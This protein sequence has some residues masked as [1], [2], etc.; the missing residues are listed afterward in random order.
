MDLNAWISYKVNVRKSSKH[1]KISID[2][3]QISM[4]DNAATAVF[5]QYYSSSLLKDSCT[6]KLAL[7]KI[8]DKW[9]I[10]RETVGSTVATATAVEKSAPVAGEQKETKS[11]SE[12]AVRGL[13]NK[14]LGSW[15]SGDMKTYRGCYAA[16]FQSKGMDLNA[17]ISYKVNVRKSSKHIKISID[18]LQISMDDNA[19]TAVF[20][21]YYS[22]SLL[23]DTCTKTLELRKIKDKWEIYRETVGS[24]AATV[25]A[26]EKSTP[27][28]GEQ[29][30][31]V[32][33]T[34]AEKPVALKEDVAA[35]SATPVT[36]KDLALV[37]SKQ[38]VIPVYGDLT[39]TVKETENAK[40]KEF[41]SPI[42]EQGKFYLENIPAGSWPAVIDYQDGQCKFIFVVPS[43]QERIVKME[44]V[45]CVLQ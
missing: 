23:K 44:T 11:V 9:E 33:A 26:V 30:V 8:D 28:A 40:S 14:W 16:D 24:T 43:S 36:N 41:R 4:D 21:Q 12:D 17:W 45:K 20:N 6:K 39:I 31:D 27:V 25:T 18:N 35:A 1:I 5:N 32:V 15:Q 7:R 19:A 22:S 13:V 37:S 10:Y 2:N 42:S 34:V 38:S 3:L 29:K